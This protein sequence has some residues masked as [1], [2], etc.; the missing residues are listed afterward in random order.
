MYS[1]VMS[2]TFPGYKLHLDLYSAILAR[3]YHNSFFQY[4]MLN[5]ILFIKYEIKSYRKR[6]ASIKK[7]TS[8][9]FFCFKF[10]NLLTKCVSAC[11]IRTYLFKNYSSYTC[12]CTATKSFKNKNNNCC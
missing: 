9:F 8:I 1:N 12:F 4:Y 10:N 11:I 7:L 2:K 6:R 3:I 5:I